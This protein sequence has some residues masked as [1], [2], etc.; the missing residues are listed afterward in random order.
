MIKP[1]R[2]LR[3]CLAMAALAGAATIAGC[4]TSGYR[5]VSASQFQTIDPA[6]FARNQTPA[7]GD[8]TGLAMLP[9]TTG[10]AA[11]TTATA[12]VSGQ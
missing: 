7:T 2:T 12:G 10:T 4:S 9:A 6:S 1:A 5:T 3:L 8:R 11:S